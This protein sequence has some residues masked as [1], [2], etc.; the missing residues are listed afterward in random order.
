M[1]RM[2]RTAAPLAALALLAACPGRGGD[3]PAAI[4]MDTANSDWEDGLSA[5]QVEA[6]ARALS[7]DEAEAQGLTVDTT[8]HLEVPDARDTLLVPR[9]NEP[10]PPPVDP[11]VEGAGRRAPGT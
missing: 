8:I 5:H 9:I 10:T 1:S 6:E 7:P 4:R 3:E 2:L 11:A